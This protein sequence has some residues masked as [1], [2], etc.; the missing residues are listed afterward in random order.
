VFNIYKS[1]GHQ[2]N[3]LEFTNQEE[4]VNPILADNEFKPLQEDI[5]EMGVNVHLVSKNKHVPEVERQ[6]QVI[7]ERAQGIVQTLPY[8]KIPKKIRVALIQYVVFWLNNIPKE[9]QIQSPR[10]IVMGEQVLDY[11]TVCKLPFG[12][13]VQVHEDQQI[14]NTMVPITTGAITLEPRYLNGGYKFFSLMTGEII[15]RRKLS[16]LPISNEVI[17]KL[18]EFSKDQNDEYDV[19]MNDD[20]E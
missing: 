15:R 20:E 13:Y 2:V 3:D 7:K 12:S 16:E 5:K 17:Q 14:T 4:V 19:I 18:E 10:E 1:R 6:N 11:K 9:D 8:S